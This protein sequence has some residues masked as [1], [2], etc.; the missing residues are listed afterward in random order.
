[1]SVGAI[2]KPRRGRV[3]RQSSTMAAAAERIDRGHGR[4]AST[5]RH[6]LG[7]FAGKGRLQKTALKL[8]GYLVVAYLVVKLIPASNRR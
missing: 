7:A 2:G 6:A 5:R 3:D 4:A 8:A 1:M